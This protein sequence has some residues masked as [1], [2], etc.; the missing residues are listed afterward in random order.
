MVIEFL[1]PELRKLENGERM[2]DQYY[3]GYFLVTA[4]RHTINQ[5]NKF[6]TS[7]EI[8]KESLKTP[9]YNFNNDLPSWKEIRS[10]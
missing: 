10:R 1:L 7:L 8:S 3:S 5:E 9:Y 4:V 6:T 2:W